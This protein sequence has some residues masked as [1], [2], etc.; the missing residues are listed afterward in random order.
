[1]PQWPNDNLKRGGLAPLLLSSIFAFFTVF[2]SPHS[3][4]YGENLLL[5]DALLLLGSWVRWKASSDDDLLLV[6]GVA[7]VAEEDCNNKQGGRANGHLGAK[8]TRR[9]CPLIVSHSAHFIQELFVE[10]VLLRSVCLDGRASFFCS[11]Q[12]LSTCIPAP[13]DRSVP[14]SFFKWGPAEDFEEAGA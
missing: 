3:F 12:P 10:V 6:P 11:R 13:P 1:M 5:D 2:S 14:P 8:P 4:F 7:E 9:G